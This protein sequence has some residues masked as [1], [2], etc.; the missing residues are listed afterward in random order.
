MP[1]K[2]SYYESDRAASEYL[3]LHFETKAGPPF[4]QLIRGDALN[5]A[6]RCVTECL[7]LR[8]L[9]PTAR[10]L[11]LGCAVGRS[12]FELSSHCGEVVGIDYSKTFI[13]IARHLQRYGAFAF[14]VF[15]EGELTHP[16]RAVVPGAF[17]RKRIRFERGDALNLRRDLGAFD[18]V[19]MANLIDRLRDPAKCLRQL[20]ALVKPGGRLVITSPYTWLSEY[21]PREKWLGGFRRNGRPVKTFDSLKRILSPDFELSLRRDLP[22]VIREHTRKF[23]LGIAEA[24]VW[25][26]H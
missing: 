11:D 4:P 18:V 8:G 14:K 26:A 2:S 22:F 3:L 6:A 20:P 19:L 23:Q 9:P 25:R 1:P 12:S 21:T 10:A 5:F 13:S 15:D 24:T 16:A 17:D 7:D